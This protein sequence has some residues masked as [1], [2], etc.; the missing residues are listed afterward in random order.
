MDDALDLMSAEEMADPAVSARRLLAGPRARYYPGFAPPFYVVSRHA[1]VSDVLR[2]PQ[3][4]LS[5]HGQGPNFAPGAGVVSDPPQHTF[6][7]SLVQEDFLPRSIARLRPRLTEIADELLD[8]VADM[9]EWDLHDQLSF[10][11]PVTIICEIFGIPTDDIAQF[12]LWSDAS[13]AALS[14]QDPSQYAEELARMNAYVLALLQDKRADGD[15]ESLLGRIARARRDGVEISDA[16]AVGLVLQLFVAGNE[17]TTSLIT[18]FVWRMLSIG[19]LWVDFCAGRF[20]LDKAINESLRFDPPLLGLF[21]TTASEVQI[22]DTTIPA[23]TKVLTHYG[24]ANRDPA[25]FDRPDVFDVHRQGRKILSFG[26]GIHVCV[27]RE[28]ALLEA[29]VTLDAL[30]LRYPRLELVDDGERIGP[31]LFWG[32]RK[33]PVRSGA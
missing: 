14:A 28:L 2:D 4:F 29:R 18:N 19:D 27:G 17:T 11:L 24:A 1:D 31:F 10:P 6:F 32:R 30:R 21:R 16:E 7:R 22:G 26:L 23:H 20:N 9:E 15:D 12:K 13:V 3:L 33:L 5:G 8:A 25:V